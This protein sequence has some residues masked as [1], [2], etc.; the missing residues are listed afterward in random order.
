LP[1]DARTSAQKIDGEV[2]CQSLD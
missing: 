2:M 1:R